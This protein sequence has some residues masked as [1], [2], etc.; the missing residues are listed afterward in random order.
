[1]I[2]VQDRAGTIR[3]IR[4]ALTDL[5]ELGAVQSLQSHEAS[6]LKETIAALEDPFLIVVVGEF[7]SGKSTFINA[8]LGQEVC[9]EGITP[10]TAMICLIRYG[11]KLTRTSLS[12][13][14]ELVTLPSEPLRTLSIVDTPGT[15]SVFTDHAVLTNN[16]F[17]RADTVLFITSA[18]RPY[19][20]SERKFLDS[21]RDWGKKTVLVINKIDLLSSESEQNR[22]VEFVS[23]QVRHDFHSEFPIF[24]ISARAMKKA[25]HANGA[26]RTALIEESGFPALAEYL[27]GT[28]SDAVRFQLK[29][30]SAISQG[31]KISS[32]LIRETENELAIYRDDLALVESV[33]AIADGYENDFEKDIRR[34]IREVRI[35]FDEIR[36][37]ADEYFD[38]LFHVK[39]I[40]NILRREKIQNEFQDRVLK[41]LPV[42]VERLTNEIVTE[43]Y[44]RQGTTASQIADRIA[45][46]ED[47]TP[48]F[49]GESEALT[50]RT[51]VL[52]RLQSAI[53]E[54]NDQLDREVAV[55]IGMKHVQTAVR[56]ALAIE[57][58]AI[59]VGAAL[60]IAAT[61]LATDLLGIFAAVWVAVAGFAVLPYYRKK[62][63]KEFRLKL[64]TVEENLVSSLE[65]S[66]RD[67][68]AGLARRMKSLIIPL[69]DFD[70]SKIALKSAQ[71]DKLRTTQQTLTTIRERLR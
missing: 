8:L 64:S 11:E 41:N 18:D 23:E 40:P 10:T 49:N 36:R 63:Q 17:P 67:E 70:R 19:T 27:R 65:K 13:W 25:L 37:G 6:L 34:T 50:E 28:L 20:E 12:D 44:Q 45:Q 51:S 52:K 7:N 69:K 62:S 2:T 54:L 1:M 47:P 68:V 59:G 4:G 30:D 60:T 22:I 3:E 53:D 24:P 14:G 66:L 61:T 32:N 46:R 29:M 56:T 58:S 42:A 35:I 9:A 15:N 71:A 55:E 39:N 38:D 33:E 48:A 5:I 43:I 16:F 31:L 26:D 21:I 57:V